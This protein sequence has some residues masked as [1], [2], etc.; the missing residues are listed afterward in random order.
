M[1]NLLFFCDENGSLGIE[2]QS[3][4]LDIGKWSRWCEWFDELKCS[5]WRCWSICEENWNISCG[6]SIFTGQSVESL[7][8]YWLYIKFLAIKAEPLSKSIEPSLKSSQ[9]QCLWMINESSKLQ[10][11]CLILIKSFPL[12]KPRVNLFSTI[13]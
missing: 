4:L 11:P 7:S 2:F 13:H 8:K 6:N 3:I 1:E 12:Q 9:F 5:W 10:C